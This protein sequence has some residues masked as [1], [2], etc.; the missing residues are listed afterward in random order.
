M[1]FS[2]RYVLDMLAAA[3]LAVLAG[4]GE[5]DGS[6]E[7][8]KGAELFDKKEFDAAAAEF[9]KCIALRPDNVDAKLMLARTM[10]ALG[11]LPKAVKAAEDALALEPK[12]TDAKMLA[13]E[14]AFYARDYKKARKHFGEIA[15]DVSLP[16]ETRSAGECGLAVVDIGDMAGGNM[17]LNRESARI[18][19]F[20]AVRLN[21]RNAPARY[22]L[23]LLY[24]DSFGYSEAALDQFELYARLDRK[25]T[26][27]VARVRAKTIP[28]LKDA[29]AKNPARRVERRDSAASA[30]ELRRAEE[31]VAKKQFKTARL[32]YADAYKADPLNHLAAAGLA[33]AWYASEPTKAGAAEAFKYCKAACA[34]RPN[35]KE[36]LMKAGDYAR[37]SGNAAGAVEAYSRAVATSPNDIGAIRALAEAYANNGKPRVGELFKRYGGML[38]AKR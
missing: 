24:R 6:A 9:S 31:A 28:E 18:H 36:Y 5:K 30:K 13:A 25:D 26:N 21:P 3:A 17:E 37:K 32:R 2:P 10:T 4:C 7:Y 29:I 33:D 12:A 8:A 11:D 34:L 19:L 20:T 23:G 15:N 38:G 35:S 27:R 14:T 1:N 16:V 22:H